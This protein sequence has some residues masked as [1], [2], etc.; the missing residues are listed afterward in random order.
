MSTA[1]APPSH[2]ARWSGLWPA[3]ITPMTSDDQIAFDTLEKMVELYVAQNLGGLYVTGST[4]QWPL[5]TL[6]ERRG[7]AECCVRV[8]AGR[9][10][11]MVHVGATT[12]RDSVALA[13]HAASIGADAVSAVAPSY[14]GYSP[15]VI[16]NYYHELGQATELP[17]FAYHL[18]T[19][20]TVRLAPADFVERLLQVPHIAGM[21]ITDVDLYLFGLIR[22]H[23]GDRLS[24]FSGAD[25]VLCHAVVSGAIGA[26]GTFYNLWGVECRAARLAM[27]AGDVTRATQFMQRFQLAISRSMRTGS[28]WSFLRRAMQLKHGLD[29]GRPR[30]PLGS[31]D[32]PWDDA[33]VRDILSLVE[34]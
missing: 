14:Y 1:T 13:Q 30:A 2:S 34:G 24:L 33:Q 10:P 12:T 23:A 26:I 22:A 7:I 11:V 32:K 27:E 18:S 16:F 31:Q 15:D 29:I 25:E 19:V 17:L 21:K 5:L 3:V 28:V 20:N 8:S 4:G 6:D 9:I